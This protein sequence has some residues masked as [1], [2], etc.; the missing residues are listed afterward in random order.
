MTDG[1]PGKPDNKSHDAEDDELEQGLEDTFPASD[2]VS[3]T[4]TTRTGGPR[5]GFDPKKNKQKSHK[6]DD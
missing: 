2:P 6:D 3:S 4:G 1:K 5:E